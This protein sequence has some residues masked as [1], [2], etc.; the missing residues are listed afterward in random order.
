MSELNGV[1]SGGW[2]RVFPTTP[3]P[4][5]R[6]PDWC[7]V[8][9]DGDVCKCMRIQEGSFQTIHQDDGQTGYL[10]RLREAAAM[11]TPTR[12][13]ADPATRHRVYTALLAKLS[14]STEHRENL[15]RRGLSAA[16]ILATGYR[17]LPIRGR[18]KVAREVRAQFGDVVMGVPGFIVKEGDH[19][20]CYLSIAGAA[21]FLIPIRDAEGRIVALKVRRDGGGEGN[22]YFYV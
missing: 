13:L 9:S 5:C 14:L 2:S 8:S 1:A 16:N 22:R 19:G 15:Q 3:C 7:S 10:H 11:P 21:G 4:I 18:A 17:T 20:S 12:N 6:R